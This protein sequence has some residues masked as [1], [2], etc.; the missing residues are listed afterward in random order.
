M[1]AASITNPVY[2]A[3]LVKS[4]GT[5]YKLKGAMYDLVESHGKDDLAEKVT[6][7]IVNVKVGTSYLH[8]IIELKDKLYVYANTGSGA[9]ETFR[10]FVWERS[11]MTDADSNEMQLICY[12]RLIY[13]HKSKD[14]L[15]VKKGKKTKDVVTSLAKK[16]GF[17]VSF[18]YSS[19]S[20]TK[21]IY[22][23]KSIAD[24]IID[25][26]EKVRKKT[27]KDYVV[28]MDKDTIVIDHVGTNSDIY[29]VEKK[30]NALA[31]G[32][33]Q[34]MEDLV[35]KVQI[36]KAETVTKDGNTEET[37]KYL[38]VTSVS[39]NTDKYGTIQNILVKQKDDKLADVKTEANEIIKEHATPKKEYEVKAV[40]NPLVKKGDKVYI[41]A[42]NLGN[43]YIVQGIE[44][45]A[46]DGVMYL[47]VKKA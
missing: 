23:D 44:H 39:K 35:T 1:A 6:L 25:L 15:F 22:H 5:T 14:N 38:T 47:E 30:K 12:D 31:V 45:D 42:G 11:V 10:G 41:S 36:V 9:K 13:L 29:K 37:G 34:T 16:W 32:Y 3:N 7:S 46:A 18:K 27:G 2:T 33:K 26:L 17:K 43:Y 8:S 4:D 21:L 24:I 20:H 28:R 40:D 19:I